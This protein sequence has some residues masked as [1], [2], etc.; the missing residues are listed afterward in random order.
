MFWEHLRF[1]L[2]QEHSFKVNLPVVH[3]YLALPLLSCH[4]RAHK[5]DYIQLGAD[6]QM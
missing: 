3:A 1:D 2:D 6:L 4:L 5:L